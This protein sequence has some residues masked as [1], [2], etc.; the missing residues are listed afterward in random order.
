VLLPWFLAHTRQEVMLACQARR[1]PVGLS[2]SIPELLDDP[3]YNATGFFRDVDHPSTGMARYPGAAF[4]MSSVP[5]VCT[6]APRLGEH[7]AQVYG[8]WLGVSPHEQARL[9]AQ[10]VL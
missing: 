4:Q 5:G 2:S 7:N 1:I 10:G 3:Q 6:R 9:R 8:S